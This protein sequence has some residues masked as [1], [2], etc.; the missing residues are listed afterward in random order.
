[1]KVIVGCSIRIIIPVTRHPAASHCRLVLLFVG[2]DHHDV[3]KAAG[4]SGRPMIAAISAS[5]SV[6]TVVSGGCAAR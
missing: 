3:V 4:G 5:V 6:T 1:V 2:L